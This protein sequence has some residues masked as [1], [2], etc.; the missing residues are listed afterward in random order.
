MP[1]QIVVSKTK[2]VTIDNPRALDGDGEDQGSYKA[3]NVPDLPLP[4]MRYDDVKASLPDLAS[5]SPSTSKRAKNT[6]P[7]AAQPV[8]AQPAAARPTTAKPTSAQANGA[9]N[10]NAD[11]STG[12]TSLSSLVLSRKTRR[13]LRPRRR[14]RVAVMSRRGSAFAAVSRKG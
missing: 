13:L 7:A 5:L 1:E 10:A 14:F 3:I 2:T 4:K 12:S 11:G 8:A 6:K 9:T